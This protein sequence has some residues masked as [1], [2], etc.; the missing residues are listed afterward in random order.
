MPVGGA[1]FTWTQTDPKAIP[2]DHRLSAVDIPRTVAV[3][4]RVV[5]LR[6][7]SVCVSPDAIQMDPKPD[8][9]LG[10]DPTGPWT[11]T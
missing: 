9:A 8:V 7:I 11:D 10:H 1:S 2:T 4:V 6:R 5:G 3:I